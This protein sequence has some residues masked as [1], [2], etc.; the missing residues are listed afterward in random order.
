LIDYDQLKSLPGI[1]KALIR[2]NSWWYGKSVPSGILQK[3]IPFKNTTQHTSRRLMTL[4][5]T[6]QKK[7][8][9]KK[10]LPVDRHE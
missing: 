10:D 5:V 7:A 3:R 8:P 9:V 4:L 2:L 6:T 1:L